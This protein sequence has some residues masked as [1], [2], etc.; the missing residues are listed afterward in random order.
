MIEL[1]NC[2]QEDCRMCGT[3]ANR[4]HCAECGKAASNDTVVN[5]IVQ[6]LLAVTAMFLTL[7]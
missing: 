2:A 3:A 5:P 6:A 1:M 4:T 7:A